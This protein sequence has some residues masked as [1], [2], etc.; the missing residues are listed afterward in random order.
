MSRPIAYAPFALLL[1]LVIALAGCSAREELLHGLEEGPANE[2]LVA[3]EEGGVPAVKRREE[4]SASPGAEARWLV[5]VESS[6]AT[7]ARRLLSERAL[8]RARAAG[9]EELLARGSMVPT[10][11]EEHARFQHA[12]AGELSRSIERLDGV[13]EARVHLGLPEADPLRPE[14]LRAPRAAVLVKCRPAACEALRS[15][16]GGI[17]SLVAGAADGLDP[18]TVSVVVAP[19]SEA[20]A[21]GSSAAPPAPPP[22]GGAPAAGP[23]APARRG[24]PLLLGLAAMAGAG[25]LG[26][27]GWGLRG[28]ARG[29]DA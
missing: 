4:G 15:L 20:R 22:A 19:G 18:T 16:E 2:V 11:A 24:S 29:G 8:P 12:L 10:P 13:L 1:L 6:G 23:A 25:A 14:A 28:R 7:R 17:R 5:E 9:F 26:F 21:V 3:L 27:A